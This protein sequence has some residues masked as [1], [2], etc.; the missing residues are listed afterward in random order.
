MPPYTEQTH[1]DAL[2]PTELDSD[3]SF[4]QLPPIP[5]SR[6]SDQ[7]EITFHRWLFPLF[8]LLIS[9]R[10][11]EFIAFVSPKKKKGNV[12][13]WNVLRSIDKKKNHYIQSI[14]GCSEALLLFIKIIVYVVST[15]ARHLKW[16][17]NEKKNNKPKK[18][19]RKRKLLKKYSE[20]GWKRKNK[21]KNLKL[22]LLKWTLNMEPIMIFFQVQFT[23]TLLLVFRLNKIKLFPAQLTNSLYRSSVRDEYWRNELPTQQSHGNLNIIKEYIQHSTSN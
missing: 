16:R 23:S 2:F 4:P 18:T 15:S 21:Y 20:T 8:V 22:H 19:W 9:H 13:L 11:A 1:S 6:R 14:P 10:F 12:S 5:L 7:S 3:F 17:W